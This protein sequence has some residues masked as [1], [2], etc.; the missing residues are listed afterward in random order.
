MNAIEACNGVLDRDKCIEFL[1]Q[2]AGM[3]TDPRLANS[4]VAKSAREE[5]AA[6]KAEADSSAT[7]TAAVGGKGKGKSIPLKSKKTS[8]KS[9]AKK[10]KKE[11]VRG[12]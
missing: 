2:H 12:N 4:I 11:K 8:A 9:K 7:A 10:E 5:S 1:L 3:S 6:S